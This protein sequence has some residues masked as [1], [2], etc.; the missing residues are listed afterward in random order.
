MG[1]V[2]GFLTYDDFV[3]ELQEMQEN[4]QDPNDV[5]IEVRL[6][7]Y[8]QP[9]ELAMGMVGLQLV[10]EV[11]A[12]Y[13][14]DVFVCRFDV[15]RTAP[16]TDE[17]QDRRVHKMVSAI[18]RAL[19]EDLENWGYCVRPGVVA[20]A[21][22]MSLWTSLESVPGIAAKGDGDVCAGAG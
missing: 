4:P 16:Y 9:E 20:A 19:I 1:H 2:I 21:K 12:V 15:G 8:S 3:A 6:Q 13:G 7:S 5:P 22:A 14:D 11:A 18:Q 10:V 17:S